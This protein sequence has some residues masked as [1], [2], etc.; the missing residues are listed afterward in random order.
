[1]PSTWRVVLWPLAAALVGSGMASLT[2]WAF[3]TL[4]RVPSSSDEG[5]AGFGVGLLLAF[6]GLCLSV[7]VWVGLLAAA[8]YRVFPRRQRLAPLVESVV[9]VFALAILGSRLSATASSL[10]WVVFLGV[11]AAPPAVFH[12]NARRLRSRP[13]PAQ[14]AR[15]GG[16]GR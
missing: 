6:G 2:A 4:V 7:V 8:A 13:W 16:Q 15:P 9:A 1:M 14:P 11:L 3:A 12:L 10:L 5:W